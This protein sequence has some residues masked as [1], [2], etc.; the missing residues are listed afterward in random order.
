ML[1]RYFV[2]SVIGLTVLGC[3]RGPKLVPV[4]GTVTLDGKPLP[5]KSLY[6]YPDRSSGTPGNGSGA[7]TDKE[8]KYYLLANIG[9]STRDQRGVQPGKYRVTVTESVIPI[10]EKDFA[11]QAASVNSAEP[12]P[13]LIYTE[14]PTRREIPSVYSSE[15]ST[16]LVVDVPENGGTLDFAL[17]KNPETKA[18]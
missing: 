1:A 11:P 6:F 16:L 17:K 15:N 3:D 2:I 14:K 18:P 10:T 7:F 5:F 4:T 12:G 9:G 8:G 13:G